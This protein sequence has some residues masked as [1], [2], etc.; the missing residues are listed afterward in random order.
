VEINSLIHDQNKWE[1]WS[2]NFTEFCVMCWRGSNFNFTK[3][4][5]I[6]SLIILMVSGYLMCRSISIFASAAIN[7]EVGIVFL[8]HFSAAYILI[9]GVLKRT[10]FNA[11]TSSFMALSGL[12]LYGQHASAE[13]WQ[14]QWLILIFPDI[15]NYVVTLN[16]H[17]FG[18]VVIVSI[19]FFQLYVAVRDKFRGRSLLNSKSSHFYLLNR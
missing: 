7:H 3:F 11:F 14:R 8:V 18:A 1:R 5:T 16:C 13:A 17:R 19:G 9:G 4:V 10:W 2:I 12:M 6:V 15:G